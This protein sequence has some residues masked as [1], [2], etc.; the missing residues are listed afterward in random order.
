MPHICQHL[1]SKEV[2]LVLDNFEHLGQAHS[3]L[4]SLLE[5]LPQVKLIVTS[6]GTAQNSL[7]AFG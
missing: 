1:A 3:I 5:E 7:G 6:Q 4:V 2:L